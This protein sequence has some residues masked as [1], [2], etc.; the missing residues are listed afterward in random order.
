[1][2]NYGKMDFKPYEMDGPDGSK[3]LFGIP[4]ID[5]LPWRDIAKADPSNWYIAVME[6]GTIVSAEKDY[7]Q[8]LILGASIIGLD[9]LFG[10]TNWLEGGTVY[11][12]KWTGTAIVE[13]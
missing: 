11:G 7:S 5:D 3:L 9:N 2:K 13:A 12:K 1:M 6:D 10:F 4:Y 8:S